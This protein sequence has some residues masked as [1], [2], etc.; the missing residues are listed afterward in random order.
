MRSHEVPLQTSDFFKTFYEISRQVRLVTASQVIS[1]RRIKSGS[2]VNN[3]D[4]QLFLKRIHDISNN[5]RG[6]G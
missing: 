1:A 5:A 3:G 6:G 4:M 2:G